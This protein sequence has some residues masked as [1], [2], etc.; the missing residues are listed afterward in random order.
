[1]KIKKPSW[2]TL[3]RNKR[4]NMTFR[5]ARILAGLSLSLAMAAAT[6]ALADLRLC[7]KTTSTVGVALGYKD[8]NGWASEGWWNIRPGECKTLLEGDL[9]ARYYYVF[10]IDY[11]KGGYWDGPATLCI[12]N[13]IFT[14]RGRTN[15]EARGY[16]TQGFYEVDTGE[17]TDFTIMLTEEGQKQGAPAGRKKK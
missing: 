16:R 5:P 15:C 14:I 9:V 13:K 6:P 3:R 1:M 8:D 2:P 4:T 10:A 12:K 11:D 7:N 17:K